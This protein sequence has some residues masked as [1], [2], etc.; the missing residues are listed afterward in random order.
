MYPWP[1]CCSTGRKYSQASTVYKQFV[2][3]DSVPEVV[4]WAKFRLALTYKQLGETQ[5][6]TKLLKEF[7]QSAENN[8]ELE[9]TLRAAA[10]AVMN[11]LTMSKRP[12]MY[13]KMN[14]PSWVR[15]G[16]SH[17][18]MG[19]AS[20][21]FSEQVRPADLEKRTLS[22][23][24]HTK[25]EENRQLRRQRTKVFDHLPVGVIFM[26]PGGSI[27]AVNQAAKTMLGLGD[28]IALQRPVQEVWEKCG[29]PPVPFSKCEYRG[30]VLQVWEEVVG[31]PGTVSCCTIRVIEDVTRISYLQEQLQHQKQLA[32]V[33]EMVE[34]VA[35][36]IR[37][38]LGSIEL[39][40]SLL[41][42]AREDEQER[43]YLSA[44]LKT[45]VRTID[46]LISNLLVLTK[47][48]VLNLTNVHVRTLL[49]QVELLVVQQLQEGQITLKR[50]LD[51]ETEWI[52]ADER[53]LRQVC[54]NVLLNAISAS[55]KGAVVEIDCRKEPSP[56]S[57]P[58]A[59]R[60]SNWAVLRIRD[61][62]V[63]IDQNFLPK[64]FDPFV[65]KGKKGTG[66]GLSVAKHV[67]E[68][69]GGQMTLTSEE[70]KGTTVS[71]YIP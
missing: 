22:I 61:Y 69:H 48:P 7:Q 43:G 31:N 68:A 66:L 71:L 33:G 14:R 19:G 45:S 39:F 21:P 2:G 26:N 15:S 18:V 51:P 27:Q 41:T 24:L 58:N 17:P 49:D 28:W 20:G 11:D 64:V 59:A 57:G 6:A 42:R 30:R 29:L 9:V 37:N 34:K 16:I 3:S 62:G 36:D 54:L 65:S 60:T 55:S 53:L 46:Q 40:S 52:Q 10:A 35:H 13:Q 12:R 56:L 4:A 38:P 32:T 5:K 67:I 47:P 1:T 25:L 8:A 23:A 70:G 63:G 44:H 50:S